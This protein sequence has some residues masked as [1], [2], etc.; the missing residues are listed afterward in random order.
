MKSRVFMLVASLLVIAGAADRASA[1]DCGPGLVADA[2]VQSDIVFAGRVAEITREALESKRFGDLEFPRNRLWAKFIVEE[3][4]KGVEGDVVV[5]SPGEENST[6]SARFEVG[7]SYLVFASRSPEDGRWMTSICTPTLSVEKSAANMA[8]CRHRTRTGTEPRIIG[9][10][11]ERT[12]PSI[13]GAGIDESPVGGIVVT[14]EGAGRKHGAVTDATGAFV[15]DDIPN[16][17]YTIRFTLPDGWRMLLFWTSQSNEHSDSI[18]NRVRI[19]ERT[20]AIN[21]HVTSAGGLEGRLLDSNGRPLKDITMNAIP[22]ERA[23]TMQPNEQFP[24]SF[25]SANGDF[26]FGVLPDGEYVLLV[27][28]TGMP[29]DLGRPPFPSYWYA[30][31]TCPDCTAVFSVKKGRLINLGDVKAPPTPEHVVIDVTLVNAAGELE[32]GILECRSDTGGFIGSAMVDGE[33]KKTQVFLPKGTKYV[34]TAKLAED[35]SADVAEPVLVDPAKPPREIKFVAV[36]P[37]EP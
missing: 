26:G 10:V 15:F 16:G 19:Q 17:E 30:S 3:R 20:L 1:C 25:S 14:L 31:P 2:F 29:P 28:W 22:R 4:F 27:N 9:S 18:E 33:R 7:Q 13:I 36:M 32:M 21:A 37:E 34:L 24:M 6:C 35:P 8:Y 5:I 11:N 12:S 23:G